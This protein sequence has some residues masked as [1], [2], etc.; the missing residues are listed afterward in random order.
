MEWGWLFF[1][2]ESE[3]VELFSVVAVLVLIKKG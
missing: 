3:G 2:S 1:E